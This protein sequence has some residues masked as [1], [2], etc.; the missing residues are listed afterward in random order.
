METL[1]EIFASVAVLVVF[2]FFLQ[3][4]RWISKVSAQLVMKK[5][6]SQESFNF[7]NEWLV[8]PLTMTATG[9]L[10]YFGGHDLFLV[11]GLIGVSWGLLA[12]MEHLDKGVKKVLFLAAGIVVC[13]LV[14]QVNQSQKGA[15]FGQLAFFEDEHFDF[16]SESSVWVMQEEW[17]GDCHE[18]M[19]M[20][21]QQLADPEG[22]RSPRWQALVTTC[23]Q[24]PSLSVRVKESPRYESYPSG[25]PIIADE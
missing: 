13:S 24:M 22:D 17:K 9:I 14:A 2:S 19:N 12:A 21:D 16:D 5:L 20:A 10:A 15:E 18:M 25:L 3:P 7:L 6:K 4:L 23:N 8:L 1:I 11:A